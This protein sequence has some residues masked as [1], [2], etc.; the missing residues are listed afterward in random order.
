MVYF[1]FL[2]HQ[3]IRF[4]AP[5]QDAIWARCVITSSGNKYIRVYRCPVDE[6][7]QM[8]N[9]QVLLNAVVRFPLPVAFL[10]HELLDCDVYLVQWHSRCWT[11]SSLVADA[12]MGSSNSN[13]C[14]KHNLHRDVS[15]ICTQSLKLWRTQ[16]LRVSNPCCKRHW[17]FWP[18]T[19]AVE[20]W[21]R[22]F[23]SGS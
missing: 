15:C 6:L 9:K 16:I 21:P 7:N 23:T 18:T 17:T 10:F 3:S 2:N 1:L 12:S 19:G 13:T 20:P 4:H 14:G 22:H 8:L 5:H 11:K